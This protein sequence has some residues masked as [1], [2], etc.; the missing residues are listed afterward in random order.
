MHS[1]H[2]AGGDRRRSPVSEELRL[3]LGEDRQ[4]CKVP[5]SFI[6]LLQVVH[7]P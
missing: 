3:R 2:S 5:V 6:E 1:E 7:L 4:S